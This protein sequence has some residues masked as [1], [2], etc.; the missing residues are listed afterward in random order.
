MTHPS[1]SRVEPRK[2]PPK[3]RANQQRG[4]RLRQHLQR[5][6][7]HPED[8]AGSTDIVVTLQAPEY[9]ALL[10]RSIRKRHRTLN[11]TITEAVRRLIEEEAHADPE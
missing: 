2:K 8:F 1:L 4:I 6:L 10:R 11:D 5:I 9:L 3:M 7:E